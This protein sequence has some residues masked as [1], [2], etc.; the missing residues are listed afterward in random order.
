MHSLL[1]LRNSQDFGACVKGGTRYS[2]H[3][4]P[5]RYG[6]AK[7]HDD[8]CALR[9]AVH[10][11]KFNAIR[12]LHEGTAATTV[13]AGAVAA[14]GAA[15]VADAVVGV[16]R[17]TRNPEPSRCT[18][19][20]SLSLT[21]RAASLAL[22]AR[23]ALAAAEREEDDALERPEEREPC[24]LREPGR[25]MGCPLLQMAA[26]SGPSAGYGRFIDVPSFII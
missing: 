15:T 8:K 23:A 22:A 2:K 12:R 11:A 16:G 19:R 6:I 20:C 9:R 21:S 10:N 17:T 3:S 1:F 7:P 5:T 14:A 13:A 25:F 24:E 4:V 26:L 18:G